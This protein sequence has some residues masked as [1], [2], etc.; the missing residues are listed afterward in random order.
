LTDK[1]AD[2][3]NGQRIDMAMSLSLLAEEPVLAL[4]GG[5]LLELLASFLLGTSRIG[6]RVI[7]DDGLGGLEVADLLALED[8]SCAA[9]TGIL[10]S[11][12]RATNHTVLKC[13]SI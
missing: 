9:A 3:E 12:A 4:V 7:I 1:R 6:G 8:V 5:H 10:G 11:R 2:H 13:Q